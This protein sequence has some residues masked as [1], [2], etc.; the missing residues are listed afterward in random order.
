MLLRRSVS[1]V[2]GQHLKCF[3]RKFATAANPPKL[4]FD[5]T[6]A[7]VTPPYNKLGAEFSPSVMSA[8]RK[9]D[10]SNGDPLE[11]KYNN[12]EQQMTLWNRNKLRPT[13]LRILLGY[14]TKE[15]AGLVWPELIKIRDIAYLNGM[16]DTTDY[17]YDIVG[18]ILECD[19]NTVKLYHQ[20]D[21]QWR[22]EEDSGWSPLK[23][24]EPLEGGYYLCNVCTG[25]SF[26]DT[27]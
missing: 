5:G 16:A 3:N 10:E 17:L 4:P 27:C 12:P 18:R 19:M 2:R 11:A 21:G 20:K 23:M 24:S 13:F 6:C 14:T 26:C 9:K 7:T 15:H 8:K 22:D 1:I 25:S